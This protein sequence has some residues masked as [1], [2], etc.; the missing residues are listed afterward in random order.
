MPLLVW[1]VA[2]L[3]PG[4]SLFFAS[5]LSSPGLLGCLALC[6]RYADLLYLWLCTH[7]LLAQGICGH[8]ACP[9]PSSSLW[10]CKF[11]WVLFSPMVHTLR[12]GDTPAGPRLVYPRSERRFSVF[13]LSF[14]AVSSCC[15][16]P[17]GCGHHMGQVLVWRACRWS[18][19]LRPFSLWLGFEPLSEASLH[20]L[21]YRWVFLVVL[22]EA[23]SLRFSLAL[24]SVLPCPMLW[25][26]VRLHDPCSGSGVV[27]G[28]L[29]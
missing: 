19:V 7:S 15:H 11:G 16:C 17:S 27:L 12:D 25:L 9:L 26:H 28:A 2:T 13:S 8:F 6:L 22:D 14:W 23:E 20:A 1:L 3:F 24:S 5:R 21:S 18:G 4:L 29:P 10:F